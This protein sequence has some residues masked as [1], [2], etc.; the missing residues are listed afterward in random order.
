MF[1]LIYVPLDGSSFAE[2]AIPVALMLARGAGSEVKFLLAHEPALAL[3]PAG[4]AFMVPPPDEAALRASEL[5]YLAAAVDRFAVPGCRPEYQLLEGVPGPALLESIGGDPPDLVVMATHGRGAFRRLWLGSVADQVIRE[6]QVPVLLIHPRGDLA[7]EAA[8][9]VQRILV[10]TDLS[11]QSKAILEPV[12]DLARL[13][14]GHVTLVHVVEAIAAAN[15]DGVLPYPVAVDGGRITDRAAT[16]RT[17]LEWLAADLVSEGVPAT[18]RVEIGGSV[19]LTLI[20]LMQEAQYDV[21]ALT[22][23]G[24]S[25]F[26]RAVLGSVADK[27]IRTGE[28]PILILRPPETAAE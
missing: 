18:T 6:S 7:A 4:E 28:K 21:L 16:A 23:H 2:E 5:A 10:A 22:T 12:R 27:M 25:G 11:R 14:E 20:Q 13:V 24:R 8:P 17:R 19:A 26:K 1:R 9:R 3:V 15:M